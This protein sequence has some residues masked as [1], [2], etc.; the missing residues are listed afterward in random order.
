MSIPAIS[1]VKKNKTTS[2]SKIKEVEDFQQIIL[3]A[4]DIYQECKVDLV[5]IMKEF[6]NEINIFSNKE[7][8]KQIFHEKGLSSFVRK[9][10]FENTFNKNTE[11][12]IFDNFEFTKKYPFLDTILH[13][14]IS[15]DYQTNLGH[16]ILINSGGIEKHPSK[17]NI[18]RLV[19]ELSQN[20][21]DNQLNNLNNLF[22][23]STDMICVI[24]KNGYFKKINP[25]FRRTLLWGEKELLERK[26]YEFIHKDDQISLENELKKIGPTTKSLNFNLRF[27]TKNNEYKLLEWVISIDH[28]N[29][30]F[31]AIGR[32]ITQFEATKQELFQ[33]KLMLEET[34]RVAQIGGWELDVEKN[35]LYWT[36][37][38]NE[39][40]EL[41]E[42]VSIE[43]EQAIKFY[44]EGESR[45]RISNFI[46]K[47]ISK[48]ISFDAELQI[49]TAKSNTKWVRVI[50]KP[51]FDNNICVK[52]TGTFQDID[53]DKQ[54]RLALDQINTHLQAIMFASTEISIIA[55][56]INGNITHFNSGSENLLGY[57]ARE[58]VGLNTPLIFHEPT[59]LVEHA[60]ALSEEYKTFVKPGIDCFTLKSRKGIP[61]N[62][63]TIFI[64]KN[65]TKINVEVSVTPI[66][67]NSDE[68]IGFLTISKDITEK[69]QWEQKI[70]DSEKRYRLFFDS[71][72][73]VMYTHD[74]HGNFISINSI[75]AYLLGYQ[76][77]DIERKNIN[78][79][80]PMESKD[81]FFPQYLEELR[82]N[83]KSKGFMQIVSNSGK[84][85]TWMYNNVV[86]ELTDGTKYVIGNVMDITDRIELEKDLNKSK[87]LAEFNAQMKD[88]FLANM[89]HEIRTPMN[90]ITGFGKLLSDTTLNKEQGEYV[91]SINLASSN[92]LH[93]INDILDFSKIESGQIAIETVEF[94]LKNQI[95][96]VKKILK[97]NADDKGLNFNVQIDENIPDMVLG[98]PTRTNQI[99]VNLVNNAIKF[100]ERGNVNLFSELIE[101]TN[102]HCKV[103]FRVVDTGIGIPKNKLDVIFK[104]FT[105]ANDNT[106]RKY[107]GTGLGLSISKSLAEI[108]GGSLTVESEEEKGSIFTFIQNFEVAKSQIN[109]KEK[110]KTKYN[111]EKTLS[112][113]LIEDNNL[114]QKLASKVLEKQ[115]FK[116][117]IA[118][119][120]R[121]GVEILQ[122]ERFD[123]ILMDLQMPEMDGYQA[124]TF[125]RETLQNNIPIIAMTAHSIVGEKEKCLKI[126]MNDYIPKPFDQ[127]ILFDKIINN[128]KKAE[129]KK[130]RNLV[131][132]DYLKSISDGNTDFELDIIKSSLIKIP[133]DLLELKTGIHSNDEQ[134]IR[135][136]AHRLKSSF[137]ILGI[138]NKGI[139]SKLEYEDIS[140][141]KLNNILFEEVNGLFE[142]AKEELIEILEQYNKV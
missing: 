7:F 1:P 6:S 141:S 87:E 72:Q 22:N 126:G 38:T 111:S 16:L 41:D 76:P 36:N 77:E 4:K 20:H 89:S 104:R 122:K 55:T 115:G 21:S 53:I 116:C 10:K 127:D 68:I 51:K 93:I 139:F 100:T 70:L 132:L 59:Q 47:A 46:Y 48:G 43:F 99:L 117:T 108:M 85:I 113:L 82:I 90:A 140:D 15:K 12:S 45:I 54:N 2:E 80:I 56:D 23:I 121:L 102:T 129:P 66:K 34:N 73:V 135:F 114:N 138:D 65:K 133:Q 112:I 134:K 101:V 32:D 124:T 17:S 83:G 50:G 69:K 24:A 74:L 120:G 136:W 96:N 61:D 119:N 118:D 94:N 125:I 3:L 18:E 9:Q 142:I 5:Y 29:K 11:V 75:G 137:P 97:Q 14:P 88:L 49:V 103:K 39:I 106:T 44:K 30:L 84:L 98:D 81:I 79:I 28:V 110:E 25:S 109:S 60:E 40:H 105:Q 107:G 58:M 42:N 63:E 31:Y 86:A 52:I 71:S 130:L 19:I 131:N 128:T 95:D 37:I 33:A 13:I 8:D 64:R 27:K 92:L 123:L 91:E 26:V 35:K 62:R 78:D 57:N 67:N